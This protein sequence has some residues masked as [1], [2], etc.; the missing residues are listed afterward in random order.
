MI[1]GC[2]K[3][4]LFDMRLDAV[5]D[6]AAAEGG[7]AV[8]K[9]A[10]RG[11][12]PLNAVTNYLQEGFEVDFGYMVVDNCR[13]IDNSNGPPHYWGGIGVFRATAVPGLVFPS[14]L[15]PRPTPIG[16]NLVPLGTGYFCRV[17]IDWRRGGAVRLRH[18]L[19]GGSRRSSV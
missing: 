17:V 12:K 16:L 8:E 7:M 1:Q 19:C 5:M 2:M 4:L 11:G 18:R 13:V 6:A 14:S 3:Q 10:G 9:I 15:G